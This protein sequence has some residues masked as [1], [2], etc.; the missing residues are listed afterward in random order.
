MTRKMTV[1]MDLMKQAVVSCFC[2]LSTLQ[3]NHKTKEVHIFVIL[4]H[5]S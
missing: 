1:E 2:T 5:T 3:K 4:L